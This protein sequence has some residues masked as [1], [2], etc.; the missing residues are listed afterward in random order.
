[1]KQETS[2]ESYLNL[3]EFMVDRTTHGR[4]LREVW[5][6]KPGTLL[7]KTEV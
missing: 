1:M 3:M 5:D 2:V 7:K 6:T 4:I